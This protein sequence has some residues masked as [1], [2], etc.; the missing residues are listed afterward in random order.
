MCPV[1]GA[2]ALLSFFFSDLSS[3][4]PAALPSLAL[5]KER[6]VTQSCPTLCNP[7]DCSSP[8]SSVHGILQA[9]ILE[10]V[11]I[12]SSR[13]I[14]PTQQLNQ[15]LLHYRQTLY[16]LSHE[17]SPWGFRLS[18]KYLCAS[19]SALDTHEQR[20]EAELGRDGEAGAKKVFPFCPS[21]FIRE[22]FPPRN[23]V[24]ALHLTSP[25]SEP[26]HLISAGCQGC[27]KWVSGLR[28]GLAYLDKGLPI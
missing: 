9:G 3:F 15:G 25:W 8:G 21:P 7:M 4:Y 5:W 14:F 22:K 1:W 12:S 24:A 2:R 23:P 20:Q 28:Q 26:S 13:G 6:L 16:H 17:G 27:W 19:W 18:S 10:S 11:T